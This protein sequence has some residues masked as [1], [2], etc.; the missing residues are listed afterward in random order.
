MTDAEMA[1]AGA[2]MPQYFEDMKRQDEMTAA[3]AL[4]AFKYLERGDT[5]AAKGRLAW[6]V[7]SYYRLYHAKGGD[8]NLLT[9]IEA[10]AKEYPMIADE[11]AKKIE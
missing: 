3:V 9:Q 7:G 8:T 5:N 10:A 2:K 6:H 1:E 11:I 4:G